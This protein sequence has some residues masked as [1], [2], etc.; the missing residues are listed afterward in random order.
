MFQ[1]YQQPLYKLF[2][3]YLLPS[4]VLLMELCA[5]SQVLIIRLHQA[6][7]EGMGKFL[8]VVSILRI[9]P[10]A[11]QAPILHKLALI[12]RSLHQL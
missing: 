9:C 5:S 8:G 7:T 11:K 4:N 2:P 1:L 12:Y 3:E 6:V 10:R